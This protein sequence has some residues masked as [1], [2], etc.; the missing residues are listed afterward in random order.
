[1]GKKPRSYSYQKDFK[2]R[3]KIINYKLVLPEDYKPPLELGSTNYR[4][5]PNQAK[6]ITINLTEINIIRLYYNIRN[7]KTSFL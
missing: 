5:K 2:E 1:L 4:K 3:I 7:K 6:P